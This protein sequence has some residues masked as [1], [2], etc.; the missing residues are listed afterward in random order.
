MKKHYFIFIIILIVS[1]SFAFCSN[2]NSQEKENMN[3]TNYSTKLDDANSAE[4]VDESSNSGLDIKKA[5]ELVSNECID[6][7]GM[8]KIE[9]AFYDKKGWEKVVG[10]MINKGA[11][12]NDD[13]KSVVVDYLYY[14]D[15]QELVQDRC[16]NCH[17]MD[18]IDKVSYTTKEKWSAVVS[19]MI[20]MGTKLDDK[21]KEVVIDHLVIYSSE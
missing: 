15:G 3:E 16:I 1:L 2:G 9:D 17:T 7:H 8:D 10:L 11:K 18:K 19:K 14:K 6:C 12:L 20:D 4:A 13:E 5:E 21:E